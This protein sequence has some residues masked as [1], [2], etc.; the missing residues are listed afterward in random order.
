MSVSC[1]LNNMGELAWQDDLTF[2]G[3]VW[4]N[5]LAKLQWK[6]FSLGQ[7]ILVVVAYF[8][9]SK[10]QLTAIFGCGNKKKTT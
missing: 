6:T 1:Q 9:V 10:S 5:H 2:R 8:H 3:E 7:W 4:F